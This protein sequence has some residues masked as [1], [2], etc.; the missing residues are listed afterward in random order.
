MLISS[1]LLLSTVTAAVI[2]VF[3]C[4]QRLPFANTIFWNK[5]WPRKCS[6]IAAGFQVLQ[7]ILKVFDTIHQILRILYFLLQL[8]EWCF[9][10]FSV[11]AYVNIIQ[12]LTCYRSELYY[13]CIWFDWHIPSAVMSKYILFVIKGECCDAEFPVTGDHILVGSY[14]RKLSWFDLDLS[15]KPY[16]TLKYVLILYKT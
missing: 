5:N 11:V 9:K 16:Q 6:Q 10:I 15:N 14:D 3:F 4:R 1:V 7:C 8:N 2:A 12:I 13:S